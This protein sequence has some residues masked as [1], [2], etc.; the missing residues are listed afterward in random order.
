MHEPLVLGLNQGHLRAP[1]TKLTVS[2]IE[3][4]KNE[5]K[6]KRLPQL[7]ASFALAGR[8][9]IG[10]PASTNI[11]YTCKFLHGTRRSDPAQVPV[12]LRTAD[13]FNA[14]YSVQRQQRNEFGEALLANP[15]SKAAFQ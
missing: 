7:A 15:A 10:K 2:E 14:C 1:S 5:G 9:P 11:M 8:T 4:A 12:T 6:C 13:G 3:G